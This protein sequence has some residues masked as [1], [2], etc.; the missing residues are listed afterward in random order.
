[1]KNPLIAESRSA[2][3][4][5]LE[6]LVAMVVGAIVLAGAYGLWSTHNEESYLIGKKID[7]QNDLTLAAKRL[8]RA[9]TLAGLGL[10]GAVNID[11]EDAAGSDTLT[12]YRN[13]SEQRTTL[14]GD[15]PNASTTIQVDNP[16]PFIEAGYVAIALNGIGEVRKIAG[17]YGSSIELV[18]AFASTY[19][20]A[21]TMVYPAARE[22]YFSDQDSSVFVREENGQEFEVATS[23]KDFQVTF[24]DGEGA[25]TANLAEVRSIRFSMTGTY[26]A[27]EGALNSMVL[28]STAIPRNML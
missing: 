18:S 22:R 24:M 2:G 16:A 25:E 10:G 19:P 23:V 27:K 9:V 1:M 8:Q 21:G 7:T 12:L 15:V 14:T 3:F 17:V 5:L 13:P 26:P 11:M 28:S 4:S 6:S 20:V